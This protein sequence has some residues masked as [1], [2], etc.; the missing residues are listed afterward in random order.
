V[1]STALPL[2]MFRRWIIIIVS[3][4]S[5]IR[6][7]ISVANCT[8]APASCWL[9]ILCLRSLIYGVKLCLP[10]ASFD[11]RW[12]ELNRGTTPKL[13]Y[14]ILCLDCR[15]RRY[16]I[17]YSS[18]IIPSTPSAATLETNEIKEMYIIIDTYTILFNVIVF[19]TEKL[20]S[21][22]LRGRH[23]PVHGW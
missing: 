2:Y 10:F 1:V 21:S 19:A 18:I 13:L 5:Y 22:D 17:Y 15:P 9:L 6:K 7:H 4:I 23:L 14:L 16:C 12:F 3:E 8:A 20:K 11:R